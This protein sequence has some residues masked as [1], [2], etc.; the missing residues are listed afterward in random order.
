L[1]RNERF[2]EVTEAY[3]SSVKLRDAPKA[4]ENVAGGSIF[5]FGIFI[6]DASAPVGKGVDV[7]R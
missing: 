7:D 2:L 4:S 1:G 6:P 5:F 3:G